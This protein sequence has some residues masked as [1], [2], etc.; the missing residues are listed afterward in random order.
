MP[1]KYLLDEINRKSEGKFFIMNEL[2][3]KDRPSKILD[4]MTL[5]ND[6]YEEATFEGTNDA[7]YKQYT[8]RF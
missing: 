4:P 3:I 1:N 2:E 7:V 5:G 6:I 8:V